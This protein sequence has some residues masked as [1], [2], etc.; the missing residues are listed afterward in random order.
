MYKTTDMRE[1]REVVQPITEDGVQGIHED[2]S[3]PAARELSSGYYY[4]KECGLHAESRAL[5]D[6][7]YQS[8]SRKLLPLKRV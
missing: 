3:I 8:L 4:T 1:I 6:F 5:K 7:R 2:I